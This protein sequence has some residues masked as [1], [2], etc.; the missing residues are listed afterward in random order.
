MRF[1]EE[2]VIPKLIFLCFILIS[3]NLIFN[4]VNKFI[5]FYFIR[6]L[7]LASYKYDWIRL[8]GFRESIFY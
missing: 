8:D 7:N 4:I 1:N 2:S 5:L 3:F 6:D